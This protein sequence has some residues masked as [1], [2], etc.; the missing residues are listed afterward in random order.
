MRADRQT[1]GYGRRGR[2]WASPPGNLA[3]TLAWPLAGPMGADG[4]AGYGFA[5]ALAVRD[6]CVA[7][8]ADGARLTLKWPNDVLLATRGHW[9][10]LSGLLIETGGGALLIGIGVNLAEA[11]DVPA[12]R[13]A[14]LADAVPTCPA[15]DA[16]LGLL[17]AAFPARVH[18]WRTDGF[19]ALRTAWLSAAHGVGAR[20]GVR[21]P[22]GTAEGVFDGLGAAGALR[23][24]TP[25]GVR[26]IT[27]GDVFF[28]AGSG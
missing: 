18:A 9:A 6:A 20:V 2:A 25:E 27:A 14:C 5:A 12:Y 3:A 10:K 28:P 8:G 19:G 23:L 11:P 22:G 7:A 1:A 17:D 26:E 21:L 4:P 15:P 24:R 13:T 16:F